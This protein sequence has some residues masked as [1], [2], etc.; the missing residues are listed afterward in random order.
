[1]EV[2]GSREEPVFTKEES[3]VEVDFV[4]EDPIEEDLEEDPVEEDLEE[5]PLEEDWVEEDPLEEDPVEDSELD[6][7]ISLGSMVISLVM[8]PTFTS[9]SPEGTAFVL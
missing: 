9:K 3:T 8:P 6:L 2:V 1:L 7:E 4:G 5:D